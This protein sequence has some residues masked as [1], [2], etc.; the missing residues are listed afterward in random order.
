MMA[1][2][3]KNQV[4]DVLIIGAGLAG[5]RALH[6]FR[7]AGLNCQILEKS[8]EVGGV[9]NY[10]RYP[11]ARCDV[12]SYDYSYSFSSEL[13]QEWRWTERYAQQP[14]I[15][16]YIRFVAEKFDLRKHIK[17]GCAL[18]EAQ[19]D[20]SRCRWELRSTHGETLVA[21]TLVMA[22][23]QLSKP[24]KPDLA[25]E[26]EFAGEIYHSALWPREQVN[27][28]DKRVGIIGTGSSGVQMTPVIAEQARHLYVFQRTANYSIPACHADI[29]DQE[30]ADIKARYRERREQAKNSP[31]GLGFVPS[32]KSALDDTP[33]EREKIFEAAWR[34]LGYGFALAYKDILLNEEAND[35]AKEFVHRKIAEKVDDPEIAKKLTPKGFPFGAMRPAVDHLYYESFNRDNVELVDIK[36]DPIEGLLATGVKTSRNEYPVDILIYATGFDAFTGSLFG[37][38]LR[39]RGGISL[40]EKWCDGPVN[41]LGLST[42]DFPNFFI[43]AGP[44]SPS[45]LSNVLLSSEEHV[46]FICE[47]LCSMKER[48][49]AE[50]EALPQF[51]KEWVAHVNERS[52]ETLYPLASSYYVGAEV[53]GKPRVFMPYSG[54]VRGYRRI[55]ERVKA[56]EWEG[57]R[58]G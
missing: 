21:K 37:P 20:E 17:F 5:L 29:S 52:K 34:R 41:Y 53:E 31:S 11:G 56:N 57:F 19:Y 24:K 12:E 35:L 54:G 38:D 40:R 48:Q 6:T 45:L 9:W 39:G 4:L 27:F 44:G 47:L 22:T 32:G 43:I 28:K 15:L 58:F 7:G 8:D 10:N 14:E 55:L 36:E 49:I 16:S 3:P 33:E 2:A 46:D 30:D 23:G 13:E 26:S 50:I 18:A 42:S 25:G 51:E 1:D